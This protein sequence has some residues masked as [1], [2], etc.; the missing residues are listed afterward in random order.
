M[1]I[2]F[3]GIMMR[4]ARRKAIPLSSVSLQSRIPRSQT[5]LAEAGT[6]FSTGFYKIELACI[7]PLE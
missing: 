4:L 1:S 5:G 7:W 6:T 3:E 2:P